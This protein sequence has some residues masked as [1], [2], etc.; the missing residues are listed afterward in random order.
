MLEKSLRNTEGEDAKVL[1]TSY[2]LMYTR[3][4]R[5]RPTF[6]RERNTNTRTIH[7]QVSYLHCLKE[8]TVWRAGWHFHTET[9]SS[10]TERQRE[11]EGERGKEGRRRRGREGRKSGRQREGGREKEREREGGRDRLA[12]RMQER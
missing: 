4:H 7:T 8:A 9:L 12:R 2:T 11:G 1:I 6:K 3:T 10:D 5:H